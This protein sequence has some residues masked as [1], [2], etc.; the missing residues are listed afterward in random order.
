MSSSVNV[1]CPN[2]RRV[3]V[4]IGNNAPL[5]QVDFFVDILVCNYKTTPMY[6]CTCTVYV[7]KVGWW[8]RRKNLG[9]WFLDKCPDVRHDESYCRHLSQQRKYE[10][11]TKICKHQNWS[12]PK[13]CS[14]ETTPI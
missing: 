2:G 3:S 4:K 1:L 11:R 10:D 8:F 5:L 12:A 6:V 7:I 13:P 14:P 9:M